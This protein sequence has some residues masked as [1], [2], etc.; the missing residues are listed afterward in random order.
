MA[1]AKMAEK[2][3]TTGGQPS[4]SPGDVLVMTADELRT[5]LKFAR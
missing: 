2:E 5:E 3:D 4:L 1:E